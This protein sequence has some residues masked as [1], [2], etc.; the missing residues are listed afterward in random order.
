MHHNPQLVAFLQAFVQSALV[1]TGNPAHYVTFDG[2]PPTSIRSAFV[3]WI[4]SGQCLAR[5]FFEELPSSRKDGARYY[6]ELFVMLLKAPHHEAARAGLNGAHGVIKGYYKEWHL[7]S[8]DVT[9][10]S[11][12]LTSQ[13]SG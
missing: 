6:E 13:E 11:R 7:R 12:A 5:P 2:A 10:Y 1:H 9:I 3:E 8:T 4:R